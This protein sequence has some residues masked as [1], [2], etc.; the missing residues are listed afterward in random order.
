MDTTLPRAMWRTLE[1]VH[2]LTYFAP[3]SVDALK[4]TGLRGY[5]MTYFAARSAP[6]GAAAAPVVEATFYNFAPWLVRRAIP[7]AWA[8]AAPDAVL[9]ARW[10]GVAAALAAHAD[11][12]GGDA[13]AAAS[14]LLSR[15]VDRACC[16]GRPLGAANAALP[17]PDDA[18]AAAWQLLTTLREHRGDGH[19]AALVC[20]G[21]SGLE[22]HVTMVGSGV[23]THEVLQGA[24][25]FSDEEWIAAERSLVE[26]GLLEETG[27][28]TEAGWALRRD[29]ESTTDRAAAAPWAALGDEGCEELVSL[30]S[31]LTASIAAAGVIPALNPIGLPRG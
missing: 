27:A 24:R 31:P 3:E 29:V 14:R 9:A 28:L 13:L 11:A 12:L 30:L 26:R 8:F 6:M 5:W 17:L 19:V 20:A 18:R 1:P 10:E 2:A 7:D 23:L 15:A 21:L 22:A 4:A 16:D 25:G